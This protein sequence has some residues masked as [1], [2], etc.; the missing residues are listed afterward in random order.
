[1]GELPFSRF[2]CNVAC[3]RLALTLPWRTGARLLPPAGPALAAGTGHGGSRRQLD[4]AHRGAPGRGAGNGGS[5]RGWIPSRR[6]VIASLLERQDQLGSP[7]LLIQIAPD[8]VINLRKAL[9]L[10]KL[11]SNQLLNQ[12]LNTIAL[13]SSSLPDNL[14]EQTN[15]AIDL[16]DPRSRNCN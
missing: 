4:A 12:Q 11:G 15:D 2:P 5:R 1:M 6:A 14:Q 16:S 3:C 13:L 7:L 10:I 9:G 8:G